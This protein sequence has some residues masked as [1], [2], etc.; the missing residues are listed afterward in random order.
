MDKMTGAAGRRGGLSGASVEELLPRPQTHTHQEGAGEEKGRTHK[1]QTGCHSGTVTV[2]NGSIILS[3]CPKV[4][5]DRLL[6]PVNRAVIGQIVPQ[7]QMLQV[8]VYV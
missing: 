7:L 1:T 4:T 3:S 6:T 5:N 2:Q 8:D